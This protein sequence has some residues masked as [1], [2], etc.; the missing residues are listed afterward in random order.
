[1]N[2]AS[3]D[4]RVAL[5]I[6]NATYE[7]ATPLDNPVNDAKAVSLALKALGFSLVTIDDHVDYNANLGLISMARVLA[8]FSVAAENARTAVFYFAGHGLEVDG[9]NYLLPRD[10]RLSHVRRMYFETIK[11]NDVRVAVEHASHLRLVLL[12]ACRNDPFLV[13]MRGL[14]G[15]R[16]AQR[17]FASIEPGGNTG[18]AYAAKHGTT[19]NDGPF[20]GNSPFAAA[21]I[22]HL[23]TPDLEIRLMFGR[24]K[25]EVSGL[26]GGVQE[27]HFYSNFGGQEL[28]LTPVNAGVSEPGAAAKEEK[29]ISSA[30]GVSS[31]ALQEAQKLWDEFQIDKTEEPEL[32]AAFIS[33]I[34]SMQAP[35]LLWKARR[36]L[37]DIEKLLQQRET[38]GWKQAVTADNEGAYQDYMAS[39]PGGSHVAEAKFRIE[40]LR[41]AAVWRMTEA[42]DAVEGFRNY[43]R[44]Y[45]RGDFAKEARRR[46]EEFE[47]A[48]QQAKKERER[49]EARRQEDEDLRA[50]RI[51]R[52]MAGLVGGQDR[53]LLLRPGSGESFKDFDL[54]PE[55]VVVPAGSFMMGSPADE[56]QRYDDES[57]RHEV[58]IT[59]PFAVGKFAVTFDEWDAC[60]ATGGCGGHK[61]LDQ[62]WG[63]GD[64]PV[65][66]VNWAD[67]Q[68]YV[69]WL[70]DKTGKKYRLLSE[71]E[72]EYVARAGTATPFWWGKSI[73]PDQA[74]YDGS[75]DPYQ[76]GGSKGEYRQKTVPVKSFKPNPWGLYQVHG[77]VWEW[78]E[79]CWNENYEGAPNDGSAITT[80]DCKNHVLRGGS[81]YNCP[82]D[83]RAA[84]RNRGHYRNR[85]HPPLTLVA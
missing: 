15:K 44:D 59:K 63:R 72:W 54:G 71:A 19:A 1:M 2:A 76:G 49:V 8:D 69:K 31:G 51:V 20:G 53:A 85:S 33:Q 73:T 66:N 68:A 23:P 75:V 81:W 67:A 12:D 32:I 70:S 40:A 39:W 18:I 26:T 3:E 47:K 36:R 30:N 13:P 28:Y 38:A 10:A 5:V 61:P 64:R 37:E 84:V 65:I 24:I 79:E 6:G 77:N 62:G 27:P 83:L 50:G 41:E 11:L 22:K 55:M 4:K 14:N 45:P 74:N 82:G 56:P 17:G 7:D 48:E 46:V 43:L 78:T 25:D 58:T 35:L 80:G 34:E 60:V 52:V 21:L 9:H 16:S 42:S 57:P 29:A